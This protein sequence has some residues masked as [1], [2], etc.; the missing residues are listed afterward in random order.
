MGLFKIFN[1]VKQNVK[2]VNV[3]DNYF[4]VDGKKVAFPACIDDISELL[5]VYDTV[6]DNG[7]GAYV[8]NDYGM[9][10]VNCHEKFLKHRKVFVD[11]K[12][13]I[14]SCY[15]YFGEKVTSR[16]RESVLPSNTCRVELMLN[17]RPIN[18][19]FKSTILDVA[20]IGSFNIYHQ[21]FGISEELFDTKG[22][23]TACV[24]ISYSPIRPVS[25]AN[26]KIKKCKEEILEFSNL[27][28]K[29]AVLQVLIYDLEILKPYFDVHQFADWYKGKEIDTDSLDP[30]PQVLSYFRKLPIPVSLAKEVREIYM[31][32]GNDIYM[33]IAPQWEGEDSIFDIDELTLTDIKQF[34]NLS[35]VTIMCSNIDKMKELFLQVGV[36]CTPL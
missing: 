17:N 16:Y 7:Y 19:F 26:Y 6:S 25:E 34:P 24:V 30:I 2:K 27:N 21:G 18:T 8:F 5:G 15:L 14:S 29:L 28:F 33:N 35:K 36:E 10:F 12:H 20:I 32:G 13:L 23:P 3:Y 11:D 22:V 4:E 1:K 9:V 31:D